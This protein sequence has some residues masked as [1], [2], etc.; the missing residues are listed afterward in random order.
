MSD[1]TLAV[2]V[3]QV[4]RTAREPVPAPIKSVI[5]TAAPSMSLEE[6]ECAPLSHAVEDY[7]RTVLLLQE[8]GIQP[9]LP[10][11]REL[12]GVSLS[13]V[14]S[15]LKR[16]EREGLLYRD[17]KHYVKLAVMG[18]LAAEC[19]MRRNR[20]VERFLYDVL[21]VPFADLAHEA[22]RIEHTIS[23]RM[24]RH[25]VL[26]LDHPETCPHGNPIHPGTPAPDSRL[27]AFRFGRIEITRVLEV[28]TQDINFMRWMES[29]GLLPGRRFEVIGCS[30]ARLLL[31]D[32]HGVIA[33][34]RPAA[35]LLM[36][37]F[38]DEPREV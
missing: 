21:H 25:L 34:P 3:S 22:D 27:A 29:H 1:S 37:R 17:S 23:P 32:S 4:Y 15:T 33:V 35:E 9:S 31:S 2:T 36:A 26:L 13:T 20:L 30:S 38:V 5:E 19:V 28:V 10:R 11:I 8:H 6:S 12:L 16:L 24:E 7:L 18:N 14:S